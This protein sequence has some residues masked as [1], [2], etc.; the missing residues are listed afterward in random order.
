MVDRASVYKPGEF[1]GL[2]VLGT[3]LMNIALMLKWI[4]KLYHNAKV[5]WVDHLKA[6]Y[7]GDNDPFIGGSAKGIAVLEH[8]LEDQVVLPARS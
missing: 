4:C 1:G 5:L 7:L 3:K 6:K 2:G 8:N